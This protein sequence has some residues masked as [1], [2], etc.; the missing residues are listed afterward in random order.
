LPPLGSSLTNTIDTPDV[1]SVQMELRLQRMLLVL[2]IFALALILYRDFGHEG[3]VQHLAK[4]AA[5]LAGVNDAQPSLAALK[6]ANATL[7]VGK[8][9]I[10]ALTLIHA[11]KL[12]LSVWC[13]HC[14]LT[15]T[16]ITS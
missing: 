14:S 3:T 13:G 2:I 8:Q 10:P 16:V 7:G 6:P 5:S 15:P 12:L 1:L 11:D 9:Q 4:Q